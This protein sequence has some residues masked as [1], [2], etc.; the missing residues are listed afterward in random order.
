MMYQKTGRPVLI[1]FFAL[2]GTG[3]STHT[4]ALSDHLTSGGF[5]V[6]TLSFTLRRNGIKGSFGKSQRQ[7]I[8]LL[9]KSMGM[10]LE[11]IRISPRK[12]GPLDF[13]DLMKWSYRLLVYN[14][15]LRSHV[16]EGIDYIIMDPSLSS[17]LK[18]FYDH[19]DEVSFSRVISFLDKN[20]FMSDI[21]VIIDSDIDIVKKRRLARGTPEHVDGDS[22]TLP[23][24]KAFAE[25]EHQGVSTHFLTLEYNCFS[26]LEENIRKIAELC[27]STRS[28]I[29]QERGKN[30]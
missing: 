16:P 30:E 24:R 8:S 10:A 26:S 27:V 28:S 17:K 19:F 13:L 20:K 14:N 4:K 21:V 25:A 5:N 12:L 29:S 11:F 3:K 18:K 9:F 15:R 2:S 23:L 22:A 7:P 1:D 6:E